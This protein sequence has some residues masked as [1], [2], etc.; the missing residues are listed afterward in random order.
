MPDVYQT[1]KGVKIGLN[2]QR[3]MPQMTEDEERLQAALL[4]MKPVARSM[5]PTVVCWIP[6]I[7][8]VVF[9]FWRF[10]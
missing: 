10:G 8:L 1:P 5:W 7:A 6:V 4:G 9:I 3:P 2:Y